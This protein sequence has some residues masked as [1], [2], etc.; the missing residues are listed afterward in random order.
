MK[1]FDNKAK[2]EYVMRNTLMNQADTMVKKAYEAA[3]FRGEIKIDPDSYRYFMSINIK[4]MFD[5]KLPGGRPTD[6]NRVGDRMIL[7]YN[8]ESRLFEISLLLQLSGQS[9]I[10]MRIMHYEDGSVYIFD[11]EKNSWY[12][13]IPEEGKQ[14]DD[15]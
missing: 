11:H 2:A 10:S 13:H 7:R 6:E 1:Y 3:G 8:D 12:L 15:F 14:P 4:D 5:G 9:G